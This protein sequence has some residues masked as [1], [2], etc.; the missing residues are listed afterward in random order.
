MFLWNIGR[1][2]A[3]CAFSSAVRVHRNKRVTAG[4]GFKE[5]NKIPKWVMNLLRILV[6]NP[7]PK[8]TYLLLKK[9]W[10]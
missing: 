5:D 4:L 1:I 6:M 7:L 9:M 3:E 10:V 8:Q 2:K